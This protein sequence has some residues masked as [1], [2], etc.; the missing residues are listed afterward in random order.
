MGVLANIEILNELRFLRKYKKEVER[1]L[2]EN[3]D[4]ESTYT[5]EYAKGCIDGWNSALERVESDLEEFKEE[6]K[7]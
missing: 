5:D 1:I 3:K 4:T 2:S 7:Q 6:K